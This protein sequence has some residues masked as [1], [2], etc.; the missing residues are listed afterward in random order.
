VPSS[1]QCHYADNRGAK[2][3]TNRPAYFGA[4]SEWSKT[5]YDND[6]WCIQ[7]QKTLSIPKLWRCL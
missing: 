4:L 7:S 1:A 3:E 6:F 2:L 5:F